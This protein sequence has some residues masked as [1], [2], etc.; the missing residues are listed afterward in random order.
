MKLVQIWLLFV[1]VAALFATYL[2]FVDLDYVKNYQFQLAKDLVNPLTGRL[3][4]TWTFLAAVVRII[5]AFHLHERGMYL[6]VQATFVIAFMFFN[7]EYFI[8]KTTSFADVGRPML[9]AVSTF[10]WILFDHLYSN[11]NKKIS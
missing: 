8:A 11:K 3:Y 6:T 5:G 4:G 9:F 7:Y 10:L 2:G 1:A